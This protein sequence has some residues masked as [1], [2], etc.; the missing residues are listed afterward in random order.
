MS[1]TH[2]H[3]YV[4]IAAALHALRNSRRTEPEI[5][6]VK[7]RLITCCVTGHQHVHILSAYQGQSL[8]RAEVSDGFLSEKKA[9]TVHAMKVYEGADLELHTFL[10]ATLDRG[11]W[12]GSGSSHFTPE[13]T[14]PVP[15]D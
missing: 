12:L 7:A 2:T 3:M 9:V 4:L 10:M 6:Q 15:T 1:H 13:Q 8:C 14:L 11:E 5:W